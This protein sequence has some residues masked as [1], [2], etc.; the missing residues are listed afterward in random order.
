MRTAEEMEKVNKAVELFR[1]VIT[2]CYDRENVADKLDEI[3]MD[4]GRYLINDPDRHG[5]QGR[6]D[7]LILLYELKCALTF[8]E[9]V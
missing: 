3:I 7:N 6:A 1:K 8:K 4:Y 5:Y 9:P 2:E